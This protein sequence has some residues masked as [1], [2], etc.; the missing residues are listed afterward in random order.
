[1]RQLFRQ[2]AIDAQREKLFGEVS[3]ARPI[4]MWIF[5]VTA[6]AF[7]AALVSFSIWGEYA[8]RETVSGY[9]ALDSGA[10]RISAPEA[11]TVAELFVKEGDEVQVGAPLA[12]MSFERNAKTGGNASAAEI[13]RAHV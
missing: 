11:G 9:L 13:G 2:E 1:M 8:R 5:T 3:Q 7:A 12:R 10:A 6:L 4:P